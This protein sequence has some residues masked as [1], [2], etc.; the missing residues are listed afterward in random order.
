MVLWNNGRPFDAVESDLVGRIENRDPAGRSKH[1]PEGGLFACGPLIAAGPTVRGARDFDIAPT[2]LSLLGLEV[3]G[4]LDGRPVCE[5]IAPG[6][7]PRKSGLP[8]AG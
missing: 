6:A 1:T 2:V 4:H 3:P 5:L 8:Y 7:A